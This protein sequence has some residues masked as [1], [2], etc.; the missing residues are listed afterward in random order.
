MV[1]RSCM[2]IGASGIT[3][4]IIAQN[5]WLSE[6][7]RYFARTLSTTNIDD[8]KVEYFKIFNTELPDKNNGCVFDFEREGK[9]SHTQDRGGS[10]ER[11]VRFNI[12][13]RPRRVVH[14]VLQTTLNAFW[15]EAERARTLPD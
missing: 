6:L 5:I 15:N 8:K 2:T 14:P 9:P 7:G 10:Q 12:Y 11:K 4:L 13:T 1:D 3:V